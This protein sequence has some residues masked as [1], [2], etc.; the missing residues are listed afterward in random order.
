MK[1]NSEHFSLSKNVCD[2]ALWPQD[3]DKPGYAKKENI[4][5]FMFC[6][7]VIIKVCLEDNK[8][9]LVFKEGLKHYSSRDVYDLSS[10]D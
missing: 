6:I 4:C 5:G 8:P 3:P 10:V 7:Y 2:P 9:A 1:I